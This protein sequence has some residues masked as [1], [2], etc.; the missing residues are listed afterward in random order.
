VTNEDKAA[1]HRSLQIEVSV[2]ELRVLTN[3]L[4]EVCHG[5]HIADFEFETRL[6]AQRDD[7]R[8]LLDR[9]GKQYDEVDRPSEW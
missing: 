4:N 2:E 7:V 9:L 5:V 3:A 1:S 6:G 8:S